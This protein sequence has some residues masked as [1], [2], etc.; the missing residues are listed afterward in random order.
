MGLRQRNVQWRCQREA[1]LTL[2]RSVETRL[3]GEGTGAPAETRHAATGAR[4][5]DLST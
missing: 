1:R 3:L 5:G 4:E 2:P